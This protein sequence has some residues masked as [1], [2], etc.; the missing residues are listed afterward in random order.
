VT[1]VELCWQQLWSGPEVEQKAALIS[2]HIF[3]WNQ[4]ISSGRIWMRQQNQRCQLLYSVLCKLCVYLPSFLSYDR[5]PTWQEAL[6]FTGILEPNLWQT[7][8]RSFG[9]QTWSSVSDYS[10]RSNTAIRRRWQGHLLPTTGFPNISNTS[11]WHHYHSGRFQC[12][13]WIW[14]PWLWV[15]HW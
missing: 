13:D 3:I 5:E 8:I 11:T 10:I 7:V 14:P 9:S 2:E 1:T 6:R 12:S 4:N 15:R